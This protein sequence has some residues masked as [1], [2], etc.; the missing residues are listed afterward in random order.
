MDIGKLEVGKIEGL[1]LEII[2]C[3][4][5][6]ANLLISYGGRELYVSQPL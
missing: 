2:A 5:G 3:Q 4:H 6:R 1:S